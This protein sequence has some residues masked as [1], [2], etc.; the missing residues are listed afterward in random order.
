M[1]LKSAHSKWMIYFVACCREGWI[2]WCPQKQNRLTSFALQNP[3]WAQEGFYRME[4]C[5]EPQV[6]AGPC[7]RSLF[8]VWLASK[9]RCWQSASCRVS[10]RSTNLLAE[11]WLQTQHSLSSHLWQWLPK[12]V[13][14]QIRWE[15]QAQSTPLDS[16][17]IFE[18]WH[19]IWPYVL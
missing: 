16:F 14:N 10:C 7:I 8:L 2:I 4:A 18:Q 5:P 19:I 13:L 9:I 12:L 17:W 6:F 1:L 15:E 3:N 11:W